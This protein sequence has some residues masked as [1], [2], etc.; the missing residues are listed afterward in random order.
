MKKEVRAKDLEVA[1]D[2]AEASRT[3]NG[4]GND[5]D[6]GRREDRAFQPPRDDA[7]SEH[8]SGQHDKVNH[9]ILRQRKS[10]SCHANFAAIR[11]LRPGADN[12]LAAPGHFDIYSSCAK[13]SRSFCSCSSGK[14]VEM[15]SKS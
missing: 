13:A 10:S 9:R 7:E 15:I 3:E 11:N 8:D 14:F 1:I 6:D 12:Q 2:Q 5:E 4:A